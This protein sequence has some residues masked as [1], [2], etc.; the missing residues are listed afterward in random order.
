MLSREQ[1]ERFEDKAAQLT[2]PGGM[3]IYFGFSKGHP[4]YSRKPDSPMFRDIEDL[5]RLYGADF[6]ILS[7]SEERWQP[8]PEENANFSEHVGLNIIM[9]R[10]QS[11]R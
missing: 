9:R 2:K 11:S 1:Q 3:L 4:S 10:K 5:E 6:E 8:K 7:Q